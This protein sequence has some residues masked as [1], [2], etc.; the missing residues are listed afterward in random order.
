MTLA[1]INIEV[2]VG[3]AAAAPADPADRL[4]RGPDARGAPDVVPHVL[5]RV[6]RLGARRRASRACPSASTRRRP[7]WR[8][9]SSRF[10]VLATMAVAIALDFMARP[11][12]EGSVR[13]TRPSAEAP[14]PGQAGAAHAR[15]AAA[16]PR[17]PRHRASRRAAA[18]PVRVGC[19]HRRPAVRALPALDARGL[20]RHVHQAR[21]GRVDAQRPPPRAG[22]RRA[23]AAAELGCPGRRP[24]RSARW[25][26][27]SSGGRSRRCS[28]PSTGPR[29]PRRRSVRSTE[30]TLRLR[31]GRRGEGAAS[32]RRRRREPRHAGH[33]QPRPVRAAPD[34]HRPADGRRHARRASSPTR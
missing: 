6:L 30:R 29:S 12:R 4:V 13:A 16:L 32:R 22:H 17:G 25:W 33:A 15:A 1:E 18:P 3:R 31:R 26:R 7:S 27:R 23:H 24:T 8:S 2:D 20:R 21:P 5:H 28:R 34:V 10:S 19:R 9:G 11:G 14:P